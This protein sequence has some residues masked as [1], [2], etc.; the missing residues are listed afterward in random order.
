MKRRI[1]T[2]VKSMK[3]ATT[4]KVKLAGF[5]TKE[6]AA[7]KKRIKTKRAADADY[8]RA[9][10]S[11]DNYKKKI[12]EAFKEKA[13]ELVLATGRPPY[14]RY[15]DRIEVEPDLTNEGFYFRWEA[16]HPNDIIEYV[17]TFEQLFE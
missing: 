8:H 17:V 12:F 16:D 5:D 10:R 1:R 6:K 4:I 11:M 9:I 14:D 15:G 3:D 7:R 2:K 13:W